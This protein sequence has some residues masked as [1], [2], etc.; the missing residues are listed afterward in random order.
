MRFDLLDEYGTLVPFGLGV[1]KDNRVLRNHE[2]PCAG[3]EADAD[4][5]SR[6]TRSMSIWAKLWTLL[7]RTSRREE[8]PK[9]SRIR[10]IV[11]AGIAAEV[12]KGGSGTGAD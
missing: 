6:E 4:A 8:Y 12:T 9:P 5:G 1:S 11:S 7:G 3:T 2:I 10:F